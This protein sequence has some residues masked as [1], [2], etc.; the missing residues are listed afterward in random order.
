MISI[1]PFDRREKFFVLL[2]APER[3]SAI[4]FAVTRDRSISCEKFWP[5]FTIQQSHRWW[6][7]TFPYWNV[8][9]A[10][11]PH[12]AYTAD[13]PLHLQRE[14]SSH[15]PLSFSQLDNLLGRAMNQEFMAYRKVAG[16]ALQVSDLD[17]V[18]A[19]SRIADFR[20][21]GHKVHSPMGSR[22]KTIEALISMTFVR[23]D[24]YESLRA[25]SRR[26]RFFFTSLDRAQLIALGKVYEPP[27]SLALLESPR[28]SIFR[29]SGTATG[30]QIDRHEIA[31]SAKEFLQVFMDTW[32]VNEEIARDLYHLYQK[33]EL[34]EV[35]QQSITK[36]FTRITDR[37]EKL[38]GAHSH[39]SKILMTSQEE[40]LPTS[41]HLALERVSLASILEKMGFTTE[42]MIWPV[43]EYEQFSYCA[44]LLEFFS[45][46]G[47][48][49]VNRWLR[50]RLHWLGSMNYT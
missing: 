30:N 24:V 9:V 6:P 19:D 28:S 25:L 18:L 20:M 29:M 47:S 21:D 48:Q 16:K 17:I 15:G 31:W 11:S 50:R 3:I 8:I 43:K 41:S 5:E 39:K 35:I 40:V 27:F 23:R 45:D 32:G 1:N 7:K 33:K 46:Q 37:L 34:P 13:I 44:P 14:G 38:L 10:V 4:L 36:E 26:S 2:I 42:E 12:L 22:A 49:E